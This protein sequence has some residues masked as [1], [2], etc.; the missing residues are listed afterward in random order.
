M[1]A[2]LHGRIRLSALCSAATLLHIEYSPLTS[3]TEDT[4]G[5]DSCF[6]KAIILVERYLLAHYLLLATL[7]GL[8]IIKALEGCYG[9]YLLPGL[10]P[11]PRF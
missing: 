3:A 6:M 7:V 10:S 2:D 1:P 9:V 11:I 4:V 8:V 5:S